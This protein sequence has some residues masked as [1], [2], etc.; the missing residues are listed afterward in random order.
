MAL[1]VISFKHY[2]KTYGH[3]CMTHFEDSNVVN[4]LK[5]RNDGLLRQQIKKNIQPK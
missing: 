1:S 4:L 2:F 3:R 5:T